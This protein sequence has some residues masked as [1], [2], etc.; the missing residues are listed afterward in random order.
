MVVADVDEGVV[1]VDEDTQGYRLKTVNL[2]VTEGSALPSRF[3][4]NTDVDN[5]HSFG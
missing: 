3:P 2:P 5:H 4:T 1:D